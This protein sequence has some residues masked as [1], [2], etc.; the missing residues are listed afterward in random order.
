MELKNVR[1]GR[2][3]EYAKEFQGATYQEIDRSLDHNP[4]WAI[5]ADCAFPSA[6]QNEINGKDAKNL[7]AGGVKLVSEGANIAGF[8]RIVII[9]HQLVKAD[10]S[11]LMPMKAV[12]HSQVGSVRLAWPVPAASPRD[13][14]RKAPAMPRRVRSTVMPA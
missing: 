2:I 10:C 6:T 4:L 11:R 8:R 14:S 3:S 9:G 13:R 1:R 7:L 12:N 5:P